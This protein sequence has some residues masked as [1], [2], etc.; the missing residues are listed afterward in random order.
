ML[1][2]HVNLWPEDPPGPPRDI[3]AA[4]GGR[5]VLAQASEAIRGSIRTAVVL[6][7]Q[8][9]DVATNEIAKQTRFVKL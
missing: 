2:L 6:V 9:A 3:R 5:A 8:E 7:N 4:Q 1:T